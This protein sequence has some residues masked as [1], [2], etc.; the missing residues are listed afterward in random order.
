M[1]TDAGQLLRRAVQGRYAVAAVNIRSAHEVLAALDAAQAL[2]APLLLDVLPCNL[3]PCPEGYCAWLR[4]L[5]QCAVVPVAISW[6][7]ETEHEL[8]TAAASGAT[9]AACNF[10][11]LPPERCAERMRI[12]AQ[13]AHALGL[14]ATAEL[15][16]SATPEQAA[17]FAAYTGADSLAVPIRT[18]DA[19]GRPCIDA[20]KLAAFRDVLTGM[21]LVLH[22]AQGLPSEQLRTACA[23][24]ISRVGFSKDIQAAALATLQGDGAGAIWERAQAGIRGELLRL[25]PLCGCT[26]RA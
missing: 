4:E 3:P 14:H 15:P 17:Q 1:L 8:L 26:N 19:D 23:Q 20:T 16:R 21:A 25:L 5:A 11:A 18:V 2:R 9:D 7:A 24:G 12:F 13:Q 22:G 10:T 6:E